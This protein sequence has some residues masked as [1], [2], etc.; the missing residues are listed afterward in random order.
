[1]LVVMTNGQ[2]KFN[3][4]LQHKSIGTQLENEARMKAVQKANPPSDKLKTTLQTSTRVKT[5]MCRANRATMHA[6]TE[7]KKALSLPFNGLL[8][9]VKKGHL[10][11]PQVRNWV[12]STSR[13]PF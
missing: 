6:K 5:R 10:D 8:V 3:N 11:R 2:P 12:K 13:I 1:M 9:K 4:T 7:E